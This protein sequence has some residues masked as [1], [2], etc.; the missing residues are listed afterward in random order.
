MLK[1]AS[2]TA[3]FGAG[4]AIG[5][6]VAG[7]TP[8][9]VSIL[10]LDQGDPKFGNRWDNFELAVLLVLYA[11][12]ASLLGF[13]GTILL[14]RQHLTLVRS[15]RAVLIGGIA[16]AAG[17]LALFGPLLRFASLGL[18]IVV[19]LSIGIALGLV[20]LIVLNVLRGRA[21]RGVA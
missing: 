7:L 8:A 5:G 14:A 15:E 9:V 6:V 2:R 20:V 19:P 3:H 12:L 16:G 11:T 4:W 21:G 10:I 13:A 17:I 1:S 18:S